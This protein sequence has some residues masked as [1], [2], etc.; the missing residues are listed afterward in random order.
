MML[1]KSKRSKTRRVI[2]GDAEMGEG[3]GIGRIFVLCHYI[4]LPHSPLGYT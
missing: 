1:D 4:V 3:I 2:P